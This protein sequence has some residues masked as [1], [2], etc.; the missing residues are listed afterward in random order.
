MGSNPMRSTRFALR[1]RRRLRA[2][3]IRQAIGVSGVDADPKAS[4]NSLSIRGDLLYGWRKPEAGNVSRPNKFAKQPIA[5][6]VGSGVQGL[7]E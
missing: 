2:E 1:R 3:E 4:S 5:L 6:G 7:A